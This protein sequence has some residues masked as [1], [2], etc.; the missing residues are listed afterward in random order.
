[1]DYRKII[2]FGGS[3]HVV[4]IPNSW[5]KKNNLK[6]GDVVYF[7]ENGNNELVFSPRISED[8]EIEKYIIDVSNKSDS[9]LKREIS[10]AYVNNF[11]TIIIKGENL[12]PVVYTKVRSNLHSLMA[13]EIIE[14]TSDK[15]VA[16]DFLN[17][18]EISIKE[19]IRDMDT[20]I[21]SMFIDS[22]DS[23]KKDLAENLLHRDEDVNRLHFLACR[24]VIYN[25][26]NPNVA[27]E[28]ELSSPQLLQYW[29]ITT[30][31]E[32]IADECKRVARFFCKV[33][34]PKEKC[35]EFVKF[36][37]DISNTYLEVMKSFYTNDR[38]LALKLVVKKQ[39]LMHKCDEFYEKNYKV[40]FVPQLVERTRFMVNC[41][42]S[43]IRII[44]IAEPNRFI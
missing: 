29:V 15:I 22:R 39:E 7:E 9:E 20:I 1:M 19:L 8:K 26:K 31:L 25:L 4:S 3:S 28:H 40:E 35:N 11:H 21:R 38:D 44:F 13:L 5:L 24:T 42:H 12:N 27:K 43:L 17:M 30:R 16:K 37:D 36:Y 32:E 34:L 2:K 10:Q 23:Y 18:K 33:K 14:Q 41:L 6:K